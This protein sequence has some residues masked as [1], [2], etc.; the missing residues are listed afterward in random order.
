M[1]SIAYLWAITCGLSWWSTGLAQDA[2]EPADPLAAAA[3]STE[4]AAE[5]EARRRDT[6]DTNKGYLYSESGCRIPLTPRYLN[7]HRATPIP[8]FACA[9][10]V[11]K[12]TVQEQKRKTRLASD[13]ETIID[14][15][16]PKKKLLLREEPSCKDWSQPL[17]YTRGS[18]VV[19]AKDAQDKDLQVAKVTTGPKEHWFLGLDLPVTSRKTL[20]YDS[21]SQTLK[22]REEHNQFF[23]S[24]NY[25]L[26]D[27]L[28]DPDDALS[29]EKASHPPQDALVR[30]ALDDLSVKFFLNAS[31]KPLDSA[32]VGLG[33]RLSKIGL[34]GGGRD[35]SLK[36][37]SLY[38]GYFWT[39]EDE[40]NNGEVVKRGGRDKSWRFGVT[41]D[42]AAMIDQIKW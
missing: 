37:V 27:I 24:F 41:F 18:L 12:V 3:P 22:P 21:E 36:G 1:R 15:I 11:S 20:K 30:H 33:Y 25:M 5:E 4:K 23:L 26:G 38:G 16:K 7:E 2:V 9:T 6:C 14:S 35:F 31:S 28:L 13:I 40:I 32:G 39:K 10:S 17:T 42:I 19:T 34:K 29:A 8:I